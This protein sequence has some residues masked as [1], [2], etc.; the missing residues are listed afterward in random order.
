M[1]KSQLALILIEAVIPDSSFLPSSLSLLLP[2]QNEGS[3]SENGHY[4]QSMMSDGTSYLESL[5]SL[6][7]KVAVVT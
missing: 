5:F 4:N 7:G 6:K 1:F 2:R 3:I